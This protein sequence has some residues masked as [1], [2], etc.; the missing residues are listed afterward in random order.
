MRFV[1]MAVGLAIALAAPAHALTLPSNG[2]LKFDVL[3]KGK[4]I[5][6]HSYRFSGSTSSFSVQVSTNIV[7][8]IP[9][10]RTTVYSFQHSS[11]EKWQGGKLRQLSSETNDDGAPHQL[12][13][14]GKGVL[15]A[16]LWN[17]DIV[18]SGKLM[19][20]IDGNIMR[21]RV[22]DLGTESVKT[23]RGK[24]SARHYRIS[25]GLER[26]LWYDADGNLA[27]VAFKADDGS[28]VTYIRK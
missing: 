7:V 21:V 23:R 20:T 11:V 14:A 25:G 24:V 22:A 1:G 10:I 15:P 28:I 18:R 13:T 4:D 3:R 19:N 8:K 5:G 12:Q 16:S 9:L 17:D 26:D 6:D 27:R 2:I